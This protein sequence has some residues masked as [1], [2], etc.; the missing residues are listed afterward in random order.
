MTEKIYGVMIT[1]KD[2]HHEKLARLSVKS[3]LDQTHSNKKLL[4]I[5]DGEYS[6]SDLNCDEVEE[7]RVDNSD[8]K[9]KLG[10]LRNLAFDH[11]QEGDVWVQWDDDD[12]RHPNLI[13]HQY[14]YMS[15]NNVSMCFLFKQLRYYSEIN[16]AKVFNRFFGLAQRKKRK[17]RVGKRGIWGT[18]MARYDGNSEL[19]KNISKG[20]DQTWGAE[21]N[22]VDAPPHYYIR[23]IHGHNTWHYKHFAGNREDYF[24]KINT[25]VWKIPVD[26]KSYLEKVLLLYDFQN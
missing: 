18:I 7:I 20:E 4:I 1:G 13:E 12:W 15:D 17:I 22:V 5:N 6:L 21:R 25:D 10:G 8:G 3:F 9:L 26:S 16:H 23:F 2:I 14:K 19:Y 24:N 11:M